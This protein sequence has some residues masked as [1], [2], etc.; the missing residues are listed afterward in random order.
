MRTCQTCSQEIPTDGPDPCLGMLPG[1]WAACCG[2]G[3]GEGYIAFEYGRTVRFWPTVVT[4]DE[5]CTPASRDEGPLEIVDFHIRRRMERQVGEISV[6][7]STKLGESGT[8]T[9]GRGAPRPVR[10]AWRVSEE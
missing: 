4:R 5:H 2:H 1:V 8:L 6:V 10:I 9:I 7:I 3:D